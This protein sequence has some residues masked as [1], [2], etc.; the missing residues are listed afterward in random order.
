M[1]TP[2]ETAATLV[3]LGIVKNWLN[4]RSADLQSALRKR[5]PYGLLIRVGF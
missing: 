5:S 3:R 1:A 2:A 4:A